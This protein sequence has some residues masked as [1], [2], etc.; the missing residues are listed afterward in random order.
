[1]ALKRASPEHVRRAKALLDAGIS[2]ELR[3]DIATEFWGGFRESLGWLQMTDEERLH[4]VA[5]HLAAKAEEKAR[6]PTQPIV[7]DWVTKG[8][9]HTYVNG[10][11]KAAIEGI[12][13]AIKEAVLAP[14][15]KR[16]EAL[17]TKSPAATNIHAPG[18]ADPVANVPQG[19]AIPDTITLAEDG[20]TLRFQFGDTV[21]SVMVPWPLDRGV[22]RAG[23][24][25][26]RGDGVTHKGSWWIAQC[27]TTA[28]PGTSSE[29]RLAV[30]SGRDGQ[31]AID[32]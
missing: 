11:V 27:A 26:V 5:M 32:R 30:K 3:T 16:L 13:E 24:A 23:Q 1:M 14:I 7:V 19:K 22:Y 10:L 21:K 17:E 9:L 31:D 20:R 18:K 6:T 15:R 4:A 25:H 28:V 8:Y 2:M 29:W 12:A